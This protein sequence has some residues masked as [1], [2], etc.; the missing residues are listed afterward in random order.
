MTLA[1]A[2]E[3][4]TAVQAQIDKIIAT[5]ATD[6]YSINGRSVQKNI[7]FLERERARLEQ[8]IQSLS[9]GQ[10]VATRIRNIE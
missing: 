4:L 1:E 5:G 8:F 2:Q 7:E 10:F 3:K 9:G 6:S